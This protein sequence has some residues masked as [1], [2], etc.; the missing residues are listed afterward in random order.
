[1]A[2][3]ETRASAKKSTHRVGVD[4]TSNNSMS[5]NQS[6]TSKAG[7]DTSNGG[8]RVA[9]ALLSLGQDLTN[10]EVSALVPR[11]PSAGPERVQNPLENVTDIPMIH[12]VGQKKRKRSEF[13]DEEEDNGN[14]P[15]FWHW[16]P[17]GEKVGNWDV[18]CGRGGE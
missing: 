15:D 13:K 10:G 2:G 8:P 4:S 9:A 16:L 11:E 14:P 7:S 6:T 3:R 18:L 17:P 5:S 1:M 12:Q